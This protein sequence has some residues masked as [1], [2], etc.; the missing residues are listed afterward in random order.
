[1]IYNNSYILLEYLNPYLV[2]VTTELPLLF[3]CSLLFLGFYNMIIYPFLNQ[4]SLHATAFTNVQNYFSLKCRSLPIL[5]RTC[6][7]QTLT[8][9]MTFCSSLN[10]SKELGNFMLWRKLSYGS[11]LGTSSEEEIWASS[12]VAVVGSFAAVVTN[13]C[14]LMVSDTKI[15]LCCDIYKCYYKWQNLV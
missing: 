15:N 7:S 8:K 9:Q 2:S 6:H 3:M 12:C 4:L 1:M 14:V 11:N 10:V 5:S 13:Y